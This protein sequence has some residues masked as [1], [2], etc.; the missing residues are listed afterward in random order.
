MHCHGACVFSI[1]FFYTIESAQ[2]V[3][4]EEKSVKSIFI[5]NYGYGDM[6]YGQA[7]SSLAFERFTTSRQPTVSWST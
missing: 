4:N 6:S 7:Q 3:G 5:G 1:L 2:S